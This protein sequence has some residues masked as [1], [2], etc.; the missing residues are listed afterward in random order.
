MIGAHV[1][2][3]QVSCREFN[4][5]GLAWATVA[6]SGNTE[7]FIAA[8]LVVRI[9]DT[10]NP[11]LIASE[12]P[13][14]H[15]G[16]AADEEM[17]PAAGRQLIVRGHRRVPGRVMLRRGERTVAE[18][19][20]D[21]GD[22]PLSTPIEGSLK[23][24][25]TTISGEWVVATGIDQPNARR[26]CKLS[27]VGV[28]GMLD[29]VEPATL[30]HRASIV[31]VDTWTISLLYRM[32]RVQP[33]AS[34]PKWIELKLNVLPNESLPSQD[35]TSRVADSPPKANMAR[36]QESDRLAPAVHAAL[37][38]TQ[39]PASP[40]PPTPTPTGGSPYA[41]YEGE[42]QFGD[43]EPR[44]SPAPA[45]P[46]PQP[47]PFEAEKPAPPAIVEAQTIAKPPPVFT[48][49]VVAPRRS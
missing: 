38:F 35:A 5:A 9:D 46:F 7:L 12:A 36:T 48:P 47:L 8:K 22:H 33:S 27:K 4:G 13:G 44:T 17:T 28:I 3:I 43:D 21:P 26:W 15:Q 42:T 11:T 40:L 2:P 37:P 20:C 29:G 32:N 34:I 1:R 41:F 31:C 23:S 24:T 30:F 16:R 49:P 6:P 45:L 25:L 39:G 10:G 14:V 18:L 19:S